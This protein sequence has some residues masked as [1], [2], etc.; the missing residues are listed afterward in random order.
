MH[1]D[2]RAERQPQPAAE[3]LLE[4]SGLSV[5]LPGGETLVEGV[6]VVVRAGELVSILGPSGAGKTTLLRAL[7]S[8][9]E[10]T[11]AGYRITWRA[12]TLSADA[13]F[14]PQRGALFDHLSVGGNIALA[15]AGA[16]HKP[17]VGPWLTSVELD[18][19]LATSDRPVAALSGGQAQRVAV[20]RT[21]AAG[22]RLLVL[23]EPSVGL[24]PLG[25]RRLAQLLLR[26]AREQR[27]GILII[28]HD[29]SLAGGASDQLLFLDPGS[30]SLSQVDAGWSGPAEQ[31][32][33]EDRQ[34]RLARLETTMEALLSR[35]RPPPPG[36]RRARR[37]LA[38]FAPFEVLGSAWLQLLNPRLFFAS[39]WVC[40]R[41]LVSALLRP[42]LFFAVVGGLLGFTVPFVIAHV[43]AALSPRAVLGMVGGSYILSLSP[44]ISAIV[45]SATSGSAVNAWLGGQRLHGQVVALEGL[46]ISP[47]RYL[48]S[49]AW[50]ALASAYA[51]TAALFVG[52]MVLGGTMLFAAYR[53]PE[54]AW[55]LLANFLDPA[56]G[57]LAPVVRMVCLFIAYIV[58]LPSITI[59]K[60]I[61]PKSSS[62]DVTAAMTSSVMRCTL[63]VVSLELLA[64]LLQS[65][66]G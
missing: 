38:L 33:P 1:P 2:P 16:G 43:S 21:L 44:P 65:G 34:N 23:D 36:A 25:V 62:D 13:A 26:Q 27:V 18:A 39:A 28:T 51:V 50:F 42:L 4:V 5:T 47:A 9:D 37:G 59:A 52:A 7:L 14:V 3:P 17:N 54:P 40:L 8:P 12:R 30:R 11:S 15:Q 24:D 56:P 60:A 32:H 64:T 61:E 49:P 6:D 66:A 48:W 22:R 46:G 63:F 41:L 57:Q 58:A 20:A 29:L 53:V 19:A 10:L 31:R 55:K 35:R 45:F